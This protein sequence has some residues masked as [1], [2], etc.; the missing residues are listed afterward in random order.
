MTTPALGRLERV[1]IRTVWKN[2]A[3]DFTPWL[4][5][6]NGMEMLG[7]TIGLD[8]EARERSASSSWRPTSSTA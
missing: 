6:P 2:E 8:L 5:S 3:T 7:E 1:D 4:A